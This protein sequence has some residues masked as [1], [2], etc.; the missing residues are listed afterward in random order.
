MNKEEQEARLL[1]SIANKEYDKVTKFY[2]LC[3][4]ENLHECQMWK[5]YLKKY[6]MPLIYK[7]KEWIKKICLN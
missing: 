3:N 2:C 5:L 1:C 7:I 6:K 4:I